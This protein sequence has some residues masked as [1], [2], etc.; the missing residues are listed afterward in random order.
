MDTE[1]WQRGGD[2]TGANNVNVMCRQPSAWS[3]SNELAGNSPAPWGSR[4]RWSASCPLGSAICGLQTKVE[5]WIRSG[6]DTA[7]NDIKML[8]CKY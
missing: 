8:C 7:L 1:P 4:Q 6:D 2:D 3:P 5:K